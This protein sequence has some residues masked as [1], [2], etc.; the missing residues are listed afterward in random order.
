MDTV[1]KQFSSSQ[2]KKRKEHKIK[3]T[4]SKR[5]M[6]TQ[7]EDLPNE[8]FYEIFQF[9]DSY[10]IYETFSNLNSRF[11]SLIIHSSLP[12]KLNFSNLSK[13]VF[14]HR[15]NSILTPNVHRIISLQFSNHLIIH[16]FFKLFTLDSSFRRLE[17]L[18]LYNAKCENLFPI[19]TSLA[20][21]PCLY[22]LTITGI[23]NFESPSYVYCLIIR[24]PV[25]KYC[26]LSIGLWNR[27]INLPLANE[28][29]SPIENLIINSKCNLDQL[30][31]ILVYTPNLNYLSCQ[32][33]TLNS[34]Q[35]SMSIIS[36]KLINLSLKLEDTSFDEFEWFISCCSEQL[37]LLRIS[38]QRDIEFLNADRW[39]KL[40]SKKMPYLRRFDFRHKTITG[41]RMDDCCRYHVLIDRFKSS[42]WTDRQWVFT[43]Q[44]YRS[45]DFISWIVFYST[46]PYR[47]N[48]YDFYDASCQYYETG[49]NLANEV[50]LHNYSAII[51]NSIDF[52]RTNR[53]ILSGENM[54]E[55]PSNIF[56][57]TRGFSPTKLT[58]L[59][60]QDKTLRLEHL[61]LLL[62][63]FPNI[64]S[65][66][67]P[68]TIL[69]LNSPL[70]ENN[71][72]T[73]NKN[74]ILKINLLDR[75]TLEDIQILNRFCL[76]LNSLEIEADHENLELILRFLLR[77]SVNRNHRNRPPASPSTKNI[78]FWQQE[79]SACVRCM[80]T[81]TFTSLQS[82]CN[83]RL[84][85]ICF[86]DINYLMAQK[87]QRRIDQEGLLEDYLLEYLDQKMY[88]WW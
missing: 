60:I 43:H 64:Q 3:R 73:F 45:K 74:N 9:F 58:E 62:N 67:I 27:H 71:R 55:N 40:I 24:L 17:T 69:S 28:E 68:T 66:T 33:S 31:D 76:Y 41:G 88:I 5:S 78:I 14:Q 16:N 75:S 46:Q 13:T 52:P 12:I 22:S 61:L 59:S 38:T 87:L 51:Q 86:R 1:M 20:L 54:I 48:H 80:K 34:T 21:L 83:H 84:S 30:N 32:I 23:E 11:Y 6:V 47:W 25:L 53:L 26:K 10:D 35:I 72:L 4:K 85:S 36:T 39:Q 37:Q 44:H 81:R 8:L 49:F 65:L 15:C 7:F 42:F 29:C 19:L 57:L 77:T 50:D 56:D 82:P 70:S 79:Y 63:Y 2:V 18:N